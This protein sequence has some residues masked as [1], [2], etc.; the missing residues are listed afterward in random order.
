MCRK[1]RPAVLLAAPTQ[2]SQQIAATM[3]FL[4]PNKTSKVQPWDQ[5][6]IR[7]MKYSIGLHDPELTKYLQFNSTYLNFYLT[8][9]YVMIL[10]N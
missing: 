5:E 10:N 9:E 8:Q 3:E 7:N 6:I 4:P 2:R 1:I